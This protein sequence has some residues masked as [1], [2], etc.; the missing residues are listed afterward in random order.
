M[1]DV[2]IDFDVA[3]P[4]TDGTILRADIYRPGTGE[5]PWPVLVQRT[6]YGKRAPSST[7]IIDLLTAVARGFI[8]VQQD[9]RGRFESEG[10]WQPWTHEISDGRDTIEWAAA[11]PGSNGKVGMFGASYTGN[12]QWATAIAGP[13]ALRAIAPGVTWSDPLDGLHQRGGALELGLNGFWTLLTGVAELPRRHTDADLIAAVQSLINDFDSLTNHGYWELPAGRLPALSRY[14][15][16]D[17]GTQATLANPNAVL[18][19][20]IAGN[21]QNIKVPSFNIGGWYDIFLQ[22]TLDN[23]IASVAAGNNSTLLVGPWEHGSLLTTGTGHTGHVNFG[24]AASTAMVGG[25]TSLTDLELQW[26]EHWLGT[27]EKDEQFDQAPVKIF[28]MGTN[29]WREEREWPL[30]RAVNTPWYLHSSGKLETTPPTDLRHEAPDTFTYDPAD[31]VITCGG[32]LVMSSDFPAGPF[33]Q[34]AVESRSDVLTYTSDILAEDLEVTGRINMRLYAATDAPSTDWVVRLCDVDDKGVSRNIT[35]GIVRTHQPKSEGPYDIDLW[36]TSNTFLAGHR[37]RIQ[38]T[39]S[40]FPRWDRNTNTGEPPAHA[41]TLRL[42]HQQ[43]YNDHL[44]PS[45]IILPV[46]PAATL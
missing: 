7:L 22:G 4:M 3:V 31:P 25:A 11:L 10:T 37:I 14:G 18:P 33:D 45:H 13:P 44:R 32:P 36:S 24:V 30:S 15:G 38:V 23:Y 46:V 16:P 42:A 1:S 9:T 21:H 6:P 26:F 28:V 43:I 29:Q 39:S 34:T 35:D 20:R 5:G 40:N 8:V 2:Q 17:I 41:T 12:T 27:R 19:H